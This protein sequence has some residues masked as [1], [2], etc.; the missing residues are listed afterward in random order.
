[1]KT[2]TVGGRGDTVTGAIFGE[3]DLK[4]TNLS[5]YAPFPSNR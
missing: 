5:G 1:M 4:G 2:L 3:T